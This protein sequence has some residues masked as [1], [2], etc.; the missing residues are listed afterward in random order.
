MTK[1]ALWVQAFGK[2]KPPKPKRWIRKVSKNQAKR[3]YRYSKTLSDFLKRNPW[4]RMCGEKSQ[5]A[6]HTR[7]RLGPLLFDT[8]YMM[9]VCNLC[10]DHC[11]RYIQESRENGW[12]AQ[13]GDWNKQ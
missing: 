1:P 9:A 12:I 13:K 5:T 8:R 2:P 3:N 4:C 10:H 7:G 11:H 6:H